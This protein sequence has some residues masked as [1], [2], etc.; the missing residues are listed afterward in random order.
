MKFI[1]LL[2]VI[3]CMALLLA[4]LVANRVEPR[5]FGLPFLVI[6][7]YAFWIIL[8]SLVMLIIHKFET[9]DLM[10]SAII[11][12]CVVTIFAFWVAVAANMVRHSD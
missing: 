2:A 1:R 11:P 12:I 10:N 8:S 6:L 4:P 7:D 5:V 3:P 9:K